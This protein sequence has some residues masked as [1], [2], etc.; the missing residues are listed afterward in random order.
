[1]LNPYVC[2]LCSDEGKTVPAWFLVHFSEEGISDTTLALCES[3]F[4]D[5]PPQE[6]SSIENLR[7]TLQREGGCCN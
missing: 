5:F 4:I 6:Y 3:C 2:K 1:M 7:V